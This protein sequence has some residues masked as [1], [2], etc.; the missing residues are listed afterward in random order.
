MIL[1]AKILCNKEPSC[2]IQSPLL[3]A[4]DARA[5]SLL[6]KSASVEITR[7]SPRHRGGPVRVRVSPLP[8]AQHALEGRG[9][10]G[11][12]GVPL[13]G[14]GRDERRG[15]GR[16]LGQ[17]D[18]GPLGQTC[19]PSLH[20]A[21]FSTLIG[22]APTRLGSHWLRDSYVLLLRQQSYAIKNQ[23]GHP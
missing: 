21:V 12:P 18:V 20:Q 4:L 11:L 22:P 19:D 16:L 23:L 17:L 2:L 8:D 7:N 1:A 10:P 9:G 3:E 6:H 15:G 5:G 13:R 14:H